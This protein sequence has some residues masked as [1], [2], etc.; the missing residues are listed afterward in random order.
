MKNIYSSLN[1]VDNGFI[2]FLCYLSYAIGYVIDFEYAF[3]GFEL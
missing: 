2:G 3:E 1:I